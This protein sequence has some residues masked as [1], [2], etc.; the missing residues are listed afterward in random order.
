M[1]LKQCVAILLLVVLPFGMVACNSG[2]NKSTL[3]DLLSSYRWQSQGDKTVYLYPNGK[4]DSYRESGELAEHGSYKISGQTI[5]LL[6]EGGD[7]L[8]CVTVDRFDKYSI[9]GTL[10]DSG[11]RIIF[12]NIKYIP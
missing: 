8:G 5:R 1:K 3:K 9:V 2:S 12:Y 10:D 11:S 4:W 6:D 7:S